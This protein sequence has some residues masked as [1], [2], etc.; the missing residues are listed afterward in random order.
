MANRLLAKIKNLLFLGAIGWAGWYGYTH[1]W[2][3]ADGDRVDTGGFNCRQALAQVARNYACR[4]ST[5]CE[6]SS[7]GLTELRQLEKDIEQHCN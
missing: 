4:E 5:S 3:T 1:W 2:A 7:A 6:L